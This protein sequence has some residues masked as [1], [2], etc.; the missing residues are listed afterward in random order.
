VV[1]DDTLQAQP[2]LLIESFSVLTVLTPQQLLNVFN[3]R[4][5]GFHVPSPIAEPLSRKMAQQTTRIVFA[6]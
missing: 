1:E 6:A 3:Q 2:V 4:A 5:F